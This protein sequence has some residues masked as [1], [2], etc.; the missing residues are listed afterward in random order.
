MDVNRALFLVGNHPNRKSSPVKLNRFIGIYQ[1]LKIIRS[2]LNL[3][4]LTANYKFEMHLLDGPILLTSYTND[5][6]NGERNWSHVENLSRTKLNQYKS[7]GTAWWEFALV[8]VHATVFSINLFNNRVIYSLFLTEGMP[9]DPHIS[10]S[11]K[12]SSDKN[13]INFVLHHLRFMQIYQIHT[14]TNWN[15]K[16]KAKK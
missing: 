3:E 12:K 16:T 6:T 4:C 10:S 9:C 14:K 11:L 15:R 8:I 13:C 5:N 2:I 7:L 1:A